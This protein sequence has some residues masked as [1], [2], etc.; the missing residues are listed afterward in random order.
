LFGNA[1][2][3]DLLSLDR[4]LSQRTLDGDILPR[5]QSRRNLSCVLGYGRIL[6]V[7]IQSLGS[8]FP[9]TTEGYH[10][11]QLCDNRISHIRG[12][13]PTPIGFRR[14]RTQHIRRGCKRNLACFPLSRSSGPLDLELLHDDL[15]QRSLVVGIHA[16][17]TTIQLGIDHLFRRLCG[18]RPIDVSVEIHNI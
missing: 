11:G 4:N 16:I 14:L 1:R 17:F 7:G 6:I 15:L 3:L 9:S 5:V 12:T 2:T 18:R 13:R 8:T 10:L